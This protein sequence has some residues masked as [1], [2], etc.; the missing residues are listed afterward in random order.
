MKPYIPKDL[1]LTNIRWEDHIPL[2]GKANAALARYDGILQSIV[3]P[4]VLLSP[5]TTQEAVLSS[6]IE[7]TQA[8]LGEVLEF[9]AD[10]TEKIA[11]EKAAD[12]HEIWNYRRAMVF[13]VEDMKNRPL[14]INLVRDLHQILLESVRGK[15]KA[16][17]E[18]RRVQNFIGQLGTSIEKATFVPPSPENIMPSMSNWEAYLHTEEKDGLVQLAIMK[19][20]F[21]LIHPFLDGN[22][23]IGRILV[24]IFLYDK[25]L[26]S[27][28]MFYISVYLE[29]NRPVYFER[30]NAISKGGD[31]NGWISFFLRAIMEQAQEN[32]RKAK[33]ILE[34]YNR[35]KQ[36]VPEITRSQYAVQVIDSMFLQPIFLTTDFMRLSK[37]P[38]DTAL[39]ILSALLKKNAITVLREAKG[40]RA[41]LWAFMDLLKIVEEK[42]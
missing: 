35:M 27:S 11:P 30:L 23:R 2:I 4:A 37:I 40:R 15:N 20:Q 17:G 25:G 14:C 32:S 10:P 1:P 16:P 34:L 3:N 13:A 6:R 41:G 38:R 5:M 28:P 36:I 18:F 39:R 42:S 22:G 29:K 31:W 33:A 21:E 19:A 7:G 12:I 8:S 26:L 24:P 9:Q